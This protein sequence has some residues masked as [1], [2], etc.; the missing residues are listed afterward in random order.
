MIR[1]NHVTHLTTTI[2]KKIKHDIVI[3][4]TILLQIVIMTPFYYK[5]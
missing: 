4:D 5:L 3:I 2:D 1:C